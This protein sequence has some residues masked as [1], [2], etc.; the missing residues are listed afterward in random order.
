M[1]TLFKYVP[2]LLYDVN[3]NLRL[4][5]RDHTQKVIIEGKIIF[6]GLKSGF[7]PWLRFM[8]LPLHT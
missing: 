5:V 4:S 6:V 8:H 3:Y 2:L 1:I 7:H